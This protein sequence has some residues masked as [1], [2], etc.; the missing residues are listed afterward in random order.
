MANSEVRLTQPSLNPADTD[1]LVQKVSS[2][3]AENSFDADNEPLLQQLVECLGDTRGMTRLR[4]A[5]TLG[6]IG[7]PIVPFLET[8]LKHH[9]NPVVWRAAA[10]T[11]I[12]IADPGTIPTLLHALLNDPDTVVKGSPVA[13]LAL[14]YQPTLSPLVDLLNH[15]DW[16]TRKPAALTL[17]KI[18]DPQGLPPLQRAIYQE[19]KP[20]VHKEM[21][22][23]I[24]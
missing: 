15:E 22:L 16:E 9:A 7:Q 21:A 19:P 4:V 11:L 1:T 14:S 13:A 8:A 12:L 24:S 17:M 3:L 2:Q 18:A 10:K 23:A 6:E 5:E 20:A